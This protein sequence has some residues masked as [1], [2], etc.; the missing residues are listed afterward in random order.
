MKRFAII[1]MLFPLLALGQSK[2]GFEI[3]L[4]LQ[5]NSFTSDLN[6]KN[7]LDKIL[8]EV[9]LEK[10]FTLISCDNINNA[11]ALT[12]NGDR[13]ILY[14]KEFMDNI[15][16]K[17]NN[18]SSILILAHEVGHHLNNHTLDVALF[19]ILEPKTLANKRK[20]ELEADKFAG[21]ILARLGAPLD[22][23]IEAISIASS[24]KDDSTSTHPSRT[25]RIASITEGFNS[26]YVK[27]ESKVVF[28]QV[29]PK[30]CNGDGLISFEE[31]TYGCNRYINTPPKQI[32]KVRIKD[33]R[34]LG[35]ILTYVG[36]AVVVTLAA[37]GI[38]MIKRTNPDQETY[39]YYND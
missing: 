23:I 8:A 10:N 6:A 29:D 38:S 32:K 31:T 33:R 4:A 30:D 2:A 35:R 11:L 34:K 17:T 1:L 21:F 20:Q 28:E 13:Y 26:G 7:I 19:D 14:D 27:G 22:K 18:W 25:K 16:W 12:Y 24:D 15:N 37:I 39:D 9:G 3:C 5:S 36:G